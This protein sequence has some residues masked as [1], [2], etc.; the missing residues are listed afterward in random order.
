VTVDFM[1]SRA[2]EMSN[3]T[4]SSKESAQE[5]RVRSRAEEY[6]LKRK[7]ASEKRMHGPRLGD[8]SDRRVCQRLQS[9]ASV[10]QEVA[11]T[12]RGWVCTVL[13]VHS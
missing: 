12:E 13:T 3:V 7:E 1:C 2:F 10:T 8:V 4:H 11:V 5:V 6:S 9:Q